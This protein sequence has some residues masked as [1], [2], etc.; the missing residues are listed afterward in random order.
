MFKEEYELVSNAANAKCTLLKKNPAGYFMLSMLA[1]IFIGFGVLLAF[2]CGGLLTGQPY[3]RI[4]MGLSFGIALS[5]VVVAGGELFT[6]NNL[7]MAAGI[8]RK[9]ITAGDAVKLW[10]VCYIGNWVGSILLALIFHATGCGTG[11]VGEFIASASATKMGMSVANLL[12]RGLLC[13]FLVCLAVWCGFKCKSES[14]K[15]IMIFWCLFAF[16][17]TGFEHS[18]ANMTL[19]TISL[20]NPVGQAVSV[21]GYF[22]N[23]LVVTLGN[24]IGGILF[25]AVPY[26]MASNKKED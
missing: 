20:L 24:M 3:A 19:L 8:A 4:V 7:V 1:G 23:I 9:K 17:T 6:G 14:G 2:T 5:L 13:N 11:P 22:Y 10:V 15:L 25:V 12:A 16:I 18:I 26:F 21:G